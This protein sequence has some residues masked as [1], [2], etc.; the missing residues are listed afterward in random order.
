MHCATSYDLACYFRTGPP[1]QILNK[2]AAVIYRKL[3]S[4]PPP[5]PPYNLINGKRYYKRELNFTKL[6]VYVNGFGNVVDGVNDTV[7]G[8]NKCGREAEGVAS[9]LP[10]PY[11]T[12][13][14]SSKAAT[15]ARL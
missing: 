5:S 7:V 6:H 4:P 10:P 13:P 1:S 2:A 8:N 14:A 12:P 9:R 15:T 3:A 11:P